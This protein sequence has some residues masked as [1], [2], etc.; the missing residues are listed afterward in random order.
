M[1]DERD[2]VL[3]LPESG[4][5]PA[6][7]P[8][9]GSQ[10]AAAVAICPYLAGGDGSWRSSQPTRSHVCAA[11]QPAA[12]LAAAKQRQLCLSDGHA[13]CATFIAAR[14]LIAPASAGAFDADLW[15]ASRPRV[16]TLEP[17]R[18]G[19]VGLSSPQA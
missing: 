13:G 12:P 5:Q 9:S 10:R 18:G 8:V 2:E 16:V 19:L 6:D 3:P 14:A 15:P 4:T 1:I 17:V 11:V 7:A